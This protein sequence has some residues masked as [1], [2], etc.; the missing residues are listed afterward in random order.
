MPDSEHLPLQPSSNHALLQDYERKR[1][2]AMHH[3][4]ALRESVERFSNIDREPVPGEFDTDASRYVFRAPLGP[5]DPDWTLLLGEFVYD[6]RASLNYLITALVRSTGK[7]EDEVNEF[8]IW[9]IDRKDWKTINER[10]ETDKKL[11][12]QLN[13]TRLAP[14]QPS[15]SCSPSMNATHQPQPASPVRSST[16]EQYGQAPAP[17]SACLGRGD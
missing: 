7:E 14:G 15:R 3:S 16:P 13:G 5:I 12:R 10:W 11:A 1:A 2:R 17:E 4:D 8:P 6:I 9:G